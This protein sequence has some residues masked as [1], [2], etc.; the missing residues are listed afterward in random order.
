MSITN[1]L[2]S[3]AFGSDEGYKFMVIENMSSGIEGTKVQDLVHKLD[4]AD[5]SFMSTDLDPNETSQQS[6]FNIKMYGLI[7]KEGRSSREQRE[8][9]PSMI[10][11]DV[12]RKARPRYKITVSLLE[13]PLPGLVGG[14]VDLTPARQELQKITVYIKLFQFVNPEGEQ[15]GKAGRDK[16]GA[17]TATLGKKLKPHF[18][19]TT[20]G[21]IKLKGHATGVLSADEPSSNLKSATFYIDKLSTDPDE[22]FAVGLAVRMADSP[23]QQV[24]ERLLHHEVLNS[25]DQDQLFS[26][27]DID[28][29]QLAVLHDF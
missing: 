21:C 26:Y 24:A 5:V 13:F 15:K 17:T 2:G 1:K 12:L 10:G 8:I 20:S 16:Q 25:F 19:E 28:F 23:V 11:L 27:K 18:F 6:E 7:V 3:L 22:R 14:D 4:V 9:V 29:D